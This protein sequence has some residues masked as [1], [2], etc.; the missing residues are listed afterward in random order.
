MV[1]V[2]GWWGAPHGGFIIGV[3]GGGGGGVS[4]G[5]G[6]VLTSSNWSPTRTPALF[7][8]E[9]FDTE[10][11]KTPLEGAGGAVV[12]AEVSCP[13][14]PVAA[15]PGVVEPEHPASLPLATDSP[16]SVDV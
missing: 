16:V 6:R 3:R 11:T 1:S 7:A 8:R 2:R 13:G 14:S 12:E 5:G 4:I 10:D 15:E 9:L